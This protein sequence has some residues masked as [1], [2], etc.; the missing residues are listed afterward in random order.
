[1]K[2]PYN[3][4]YRGSM[5]TSVGNILEK[6]LDAGFHPISKSAPGTSDRQVSTHPDVL[7]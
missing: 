1:M 3:F 5:Q 4:K 6:V 2:L 7:R